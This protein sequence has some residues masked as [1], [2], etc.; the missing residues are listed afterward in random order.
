MPIPP[1][2]GPAETGTRGR[3]LR[4]CNTQAEGQKHLK[5]KLVIRK[6]M[7]QTKC[8]LSEPALIP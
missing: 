7:E 3:T 8:R 4:G 6:G 2:D 1:S 5:G